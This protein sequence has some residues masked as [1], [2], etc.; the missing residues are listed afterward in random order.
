[1]TFAR[2]A[3]IFTFFLIFRLVLSYIYFSMYIVCPDGYFGQNCS[4]PCTPGLYGP[5]C[6][7]KCN[8]SHCH[9]V[10]GCY[11][12]SGKNILDVDPL[13]L[14]SFFLLI[15]DLSLFECFQHNLFLYKR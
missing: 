6:V 14:N 8:C 12:R 11:E 15:Q 3:R 1:M 7:E 2:Q 4:K 5:G 9:H 10:Y 13:Q